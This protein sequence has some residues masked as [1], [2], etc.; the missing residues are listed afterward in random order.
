M[1][2]SPSGLFWIPLLG[3]RHPPGLG[4]TFARV[5]TWQPLSLIVIQAA[6]QR[7][8]SR[9]LKAPS[10]R[11]KKKEQQKGRERERRHGAVGDFR[12]THH[13][14]QPRSL[15]AALDH[16]IAARLTLLRVADPGIP[17]YKVRRTKD[18]RRKTPAANQ[19]RV[20]V[21]CGTANP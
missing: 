9:I 7:P 5:G 20:D 19:P 4:P 16:R 12:Q 6:R 17:P 13:S 11:N 15:S 8:L 10:E 14:Q 18:E 1:S 3:A 2:E 21:G